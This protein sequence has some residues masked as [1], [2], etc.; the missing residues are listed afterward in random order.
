MFVF[1]LAQTKP[2]LRIDLDLR[3]VTF[4][5]LLD[6]TRFNVSEQETDLKPLIQPGIYNGIPYCYKTTKLSDFMFV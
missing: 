6:P 5:V 4:S 1:L 2:I 3:K